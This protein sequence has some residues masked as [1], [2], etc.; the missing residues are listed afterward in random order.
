VWRWLR[1]FHISGASRHFTRVRPARRRSP[2]A[3]GVDSTVRRNEF[4]D[5]AD[6]Q[7]NLKAAQADTIELTPRENHVRRYLVAIGIMLGAA[8]AAS[9]AT[10][11][12]FVSVL[13]QDANTAS[14]CSV[15]FPCR[16]FGAAIGVTNANGEIIA[17]DSGGYGPVTISQSITIESPAG[18]Y[19][20]ISVAAGLDGVTING[21]SI[22]V[23]LRG[24]SINGQGGNRGIVLGGNNNTLYVERCT[25]SNMALDGMLLFS[26]SSRVHVADTVVANGGSFGINMNDLEMFEG[27]RLTVVRHNNYGIGIANTRVATVRDSIVSESN[28]FA[29]GI[30]AQVATPV[31]VTLSRLELH[32]NLAGA[33]EVSATST[34]PATASIADSSLLDNGA[35]VPANGTIKVAATS[36]AKAEIA[37]DRTVV[38]RNFGDAVFVTG[39]GAKASVSLSTLTSNLG[40][41][42][43]NSA[44][45]LYT[46]QNNTIRG[47]FGAEIVN[48]TLG[49]ISNL[50]G[51]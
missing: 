30:Y 39:T 33:I 28:L 31:T 50:L 34:G 47:N 18:V 32:D 38:M 49:T 9:A 10:Q 2:K 21:S 11:R 15:A 45:T 24:L 3:A 44:G 51:S 20:G 40:Y 16:S 35:G 14:N 25:I 22:K 4:H 29:I 27:N 6:L 13:G 26:A 46:R 17:L 48:Q 8:T 37:I 5:A 43:N 36:P 41:A 1:S 23:T 12:A 42:L 7:G 19:A